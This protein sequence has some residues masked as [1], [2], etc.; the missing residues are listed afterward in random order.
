M[1]IERLLL[2]IGFLARRLEG[3]RDVAEHARRIVRAAAA[4]RLQRWKRQHVGRLVDAAPVAVER[5]NAGVVGQHHCQFGF[6]DIGFRNLGGGRDGALDDRFGV[7]LALP[8]VGD[9]ENLGYGKGK[10]C[11]RSGISIAAGVRP[12]RTFGGRLLHQGLLVAGRC[13]NPS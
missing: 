9:H 13:G 7:G 5:A 8:A 4:V 12:R 11:H 10:W 1:M 3:D 6:A 2:V